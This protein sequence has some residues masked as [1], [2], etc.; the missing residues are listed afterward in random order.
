MAAVFV[1]AVAEGDPPQRV[2]SLSPSVTEILYGVGA[3]DKVVAVS[4]YCT[5]PPQ[6][7]RLPRV[8]DWM[9]T[10]LE[11]ITSFRPDLVIMADAQ[12]PFIEDRLA[13]LGLATLVV[14]GQSLS[15]VYDAIEAIGEAVGSREEGERLARQTRMELEAIGRR[16]KGLARPRVLCVVDRIPGTLRDLYV[17]TGGSFL[18]ELIEI[19]GGEPITPPAAMSYARVTME[20]VV[21]LDPD[22]ILDVVQALHAPVTLLPAQGSLTEDPLAVWGELAQVRAVRDGR[23]HPLRD[24]TLIHPSQLVVQTARRIARALHPEVF[25]PRSDSHRRTN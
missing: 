20:A 25:E 18:A 2:I 21:S 11:K 16:A 19:A 3:L 15:D 8:G 12:A 24:T 7:A 22:V 4:N 6:V 10:S 1:S 9:T 23:V 13:A 5:Y 17:A 14:P